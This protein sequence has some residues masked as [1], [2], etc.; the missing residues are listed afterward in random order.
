MLLPRVGGGLGGGATMLMTTGRWYTRSL[1]LESPSLPGGSHPTVRSSQT[2]SSTLRGGPYHPSHKFPR[3]GK[4][5]PLLSLPEGKLF[6]IK[7]GT[8]ATEGSFH[9]RLRLRQTPFS[10]PTSHNLAPT[11]GPPSQSPLTHPIS[12]SPSAITAF[13]LDQPASSDLTIPTPHP[14]VRIPRY[15][16]IQRPHSGCAY[17][18]LPACP[19]P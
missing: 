10:H 3:L 8:R 15:E 1:M 17:G 11:F 12:Y 9:A 6:C 18:T 19:R 4:L 14:Y 5:R 13:L 16:S 7:G 2:P